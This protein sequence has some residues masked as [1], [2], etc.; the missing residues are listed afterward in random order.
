MKN[1]LLAV[2]LMA[3]LVVPVSAGTIW[4]GIED[5]KLPGGDKDYNDM[6][7]R[8]TGNNLSATG[9]GSWKQM[10]VPDMNGTPFWDN[11]STDGSG[12]YNVGYFMTGTGVFG[13]NLNSPKFAVADLQYWGV[14]SSADN[15]FMLFSTGSDSATMLLEVAA[16][17]GQNQ[18]YWFNQATPSTLNLLFAGSATA[19]AMANFAPNGN[20]GLLLNSP[21]GIYRTT[22]DGAQFAMFQQTPIPEPA[23]FALFWLGLS[24]LALVHRRRS[25]R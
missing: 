24:G 1:L 15:S 23:S 5:Q 25:S 13:S 10:V 2:L 8:L 9:S 17:A 7:F 11:G 6:V 22:S 12:G 3:L 19:G 21:G 20:F 4:I 18:L 16:W 14:G